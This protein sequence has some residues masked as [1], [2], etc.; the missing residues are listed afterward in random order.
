MV[1][2]M[3]KTGRYICAG[4]TE[5]RRPLA[6]NDAWFVHLSFLMVLREVAET[7]LDSFSYLAKLD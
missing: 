1:I 7:V 2:F 3:M 4:E 5:A 6:G